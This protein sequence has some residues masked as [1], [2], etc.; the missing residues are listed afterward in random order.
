MFRLLIIP[1]SFNIRGP[2]GTEL[3]DSLSELTHRAGVIRHGHDLRAGVR[4]YH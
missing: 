3:I 1:D 4:E 2:N